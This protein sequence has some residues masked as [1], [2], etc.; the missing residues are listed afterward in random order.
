MPG[1]VLAFSPDPAAASHVDTMTAALGPERAASRGRAS[2]DAL[3]L[4]IGWSQHAGSSADCA[5]V[6]N[7]TRTVCLVL[8]GEVHPEPTLLHALRARGHAFDPHDASHIVH[9]YEEQGA[10]FVAGLNGWF[11][12]VLV[13]RVA[14]RALLFNDRYG[15]S[16]VHLHATAD[17]LYAASEAKALLHALPSLRR[18]DESALA[19]VQAFGCVLNDRT[20]YPDIT[21]LPAGSMWQLVAGGA[22]SRGRWFEPDDWREASPLPTPA[23]LEELREVLARRFPRYLQ[24]RQPVGMSLTGGLDGR[25]VMAWAPQPAGA[26]PCYSFGGPVRDGVDAVLA[27]RIA[28]ACGQPHQTL[29]VGD[30]FLHDFERLAARAVYLSDGEMD[31]SGAIELHLNERARAIAPVRLTG[32]YGSEVLRGH[33]AFR[34]RAQDPEAFEPRFAQAVR[35]AAQAWHTLRAQHDALGF[36]IG[37]QVPWH[38]HSRLA[39]EQS[40]LTPRSPFLDNELVALMFRAPPAWREGTGLSLRLVAEAAPALAGIPTD[41]GLV[42]GDTS[43]RRQLHM[44]WQTFTMKAEY[45]WD[46]GMPPTLARIEGAL[47]PLHLER[48]FLGHHKFAHF[49]IWYR[50]ALAGVLRDVLLTP[51]ALSRSVYRPQALRQMVEAHLAGRANHTLA[52]HRA[53][54]HE[55]IHRELLAP[56]A[57][58]AR[59]PAP[60][61]TAAPASPALPRIDVCVCTYRRPQ[62]L[63]QLLD[64]LA[65]QDT[66]GRFTLAL[67]VVDND[68]AASAAPIVQAF[69]SRVAV[70]L[71]HAHEPEANIARARNRACAL[72]E[73]EF[74]AMIDD[75]ELP[76]PDWLAQMLTT[77]QDSG[78]DG[79]LGPVRPRYEAPPP[80]WVLRGG[81]CE[82][83]RHAT[84]TR[85]HRARELRTGN[86][87]IRRTR[88]LAETGPFDPA[89]GRSGGEDT[90]FFRR[91]LARGDTYR[92]CDEAPVWEAVPAE[93]LTRGYFLRRAWV[94]GVVNAGRVRL[95]STDAVKSLAAA[96]L[97]TLALPLLAPIPHLFMHALV[98]NCD[99]LGK[100]LALCG[101]Q[102]VRERRG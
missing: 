20:I 96:G 70:P 45:A 80:G 37:C 57:R 97:Y 82:R 32:N 43:A 65:T 54:G 56:Q 48:L 71:R 6:W 46:V 89:L 99:H 66:R 64:A 8:A 9:L 5:P 19:Q 53:L 4:E 36:V 102:P 101:W 79:V 21:L 92:W 75:D 38:H 100:L 22:V 51:T 84:G 12:G 59:A 39:L 72:A 91:R 26:L 68:P 24:G 34:P 13:D 7:E 95:L 16:R 67:V 63:A 77:L 14:R 2:L 81:F 98:R 10:A 73:G 83:A 35:D 30:S 28:Q 78:A 27:R 47:A 11:S 44:R 15:L 85:L 40:Q 1:F 60:L 94:R 25:L 33:L 93:R 62:Q 58:P 3:G 74:V 17:G 87:L 61:A 42:A 29:H 55:Y 23:F 31:A 76:G 49:R 52:L 88:L 50:E 90:D 86:L 41:R 69:S 18:L